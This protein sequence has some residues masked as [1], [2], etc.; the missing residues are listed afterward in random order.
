VFRDDFF[1]DCCLEEGGCCGLF[2]LPVPEGFGLYFFQGLFLAGGTL[3]LKRYD[4]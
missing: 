4:F 1:A 3:P 2:I